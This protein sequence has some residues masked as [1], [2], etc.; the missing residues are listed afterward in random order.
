MQSKQGLAVLRCDVF[1]SL[2]SLPSLKSMR[3]ANGDIFTCL[4]AV[5]R[6]PLCRPGVPQQCMKGVLAGR[7]PA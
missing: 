6:A 2:S 5:C 7:T 1:G 3:A 4:L